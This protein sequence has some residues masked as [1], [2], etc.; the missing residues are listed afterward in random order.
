[1]VVSV[2]AHHSSCT[3]C[4]ELAISDNNNGSWTNLEWK[5]IIYVKVNEILEVWQGLVRPIYP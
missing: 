2:H 4:Y 5:V 1:M 3:L